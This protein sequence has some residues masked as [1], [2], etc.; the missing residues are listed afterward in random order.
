MD[1]IPRIALEQI[2][3]ADI[4]IALLS[5]RNQ[6]VAYELGYRRAREQTPV[7]LIVD[8]KDDLPVYESA[9]A[10]QGWKQDDVL[11][12]ID[13][14]AGSDFPPLA[15]FE[16]DIP[17]DL[18]DVIDAIDDGLVNELAI[19]SPRDRKQALSCCFA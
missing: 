8:S 11:K 13:S 12:Q 4:L 10:Y 3:R 1:E 16:V 2:C 6:T 5:E 17:G 18:K 14:I 19:G 15:D 7:I 9:V